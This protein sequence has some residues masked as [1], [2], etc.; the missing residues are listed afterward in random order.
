MS[1]GFP[2]T[3]AFFLHVHHKGKI[4]GVYN[5]CAFSIDSLHWAVDPWFLDFK[6]RSRV[7]NF[8]NAK[9]PFEPL[10]LMS[11]ICKISEWPQYFM[12]MLKSK[13]FVV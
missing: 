8:Y 9:K 10:L 13:P 3:T 1:D 2:S 11:K 7:N 5:T 4:C 12:F 6:F